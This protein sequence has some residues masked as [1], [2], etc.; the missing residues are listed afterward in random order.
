MNRTVARLTLRGLLGR[1]RAILLFVLPALLIVIS[2]FVRVLVGHDDSV[3]TDLLS[4]FAIGT[5]I[6]L[7]G[8]IAGTGAIA[9][10]ID[11]G[12]IIYLLA[13]PVRRPRIVLTKLVVATGVTIAFAAVPTFIA[14]LVLSGTSERIA[15]AFGAA[16]LVSCV[17]YAAI[18]LLLGVVTRHAAIVGLIYAL[19]WEGLVGSLISGAKTLS[20]QQWSLSLARR[21]AADGAVGSAVRLPVAVVLL[22]VVTVAATWF[23]GQRLRSLTLA[24]EE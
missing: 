16:A 11:D 24:G 15:L 7:V 23:A 5:M 2:A 3:S 20:V 1:R 21:I 17:A 10:E 6:P 14:A 4:G 8:V 13:K 19:V 18:F 22:A 9:P 12:S